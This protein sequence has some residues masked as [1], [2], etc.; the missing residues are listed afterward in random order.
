MLFEVYDFACALDV[1]HHWPLFNDASRDELS[2]PRDSHHLDR[3]H[4]LLAFP[5]RLSN[6]PGAALS[7]H[8]HV[9]EVGCPQLVA[10]NLR[11]GLMVY[12]LGFGERRLAARRSW[13]AIS[14]TGLGFSI[15][16]WVRF[17]LVDPLT[18]GLLAICARPPGPW[19]VVPACEMCS[20]P[21]LHLEVAV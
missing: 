15:Y 1:G 18:S 14:D 6:K 8:L 11:P 5:Q 12:G 2:G 19:M 4:R 13:H 21:S 17:A 10:Y 9:L 16:L 20:S 3:H 7:N